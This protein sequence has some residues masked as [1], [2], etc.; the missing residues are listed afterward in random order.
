M[1]D[2]LFGKRNKRGDWSPRERIEYPPVFAWPPRP[3]AFVRFLTGLS[4]Y[5][6]PW[7]VLYALIALL[8]LRYATPSLATAQTFS[9]GW[10]GLLLARNAALVTA[11]VGLWHLVLYVLRRQ[12]TSFKFSARWP[13]TDNSAFLFKHQLADNL[14]WTYASGLP[15]WTATE[16]LMLWAMGNHYVPYVDWQTH[17]VYCFAILLAIPMFRDL[18][19]YCV[20]RLLHWPPLYRHV[21][22]LHH[23]NV[24]PIPSSGLSMH[25]VE[26]VLYY[27]S[28]LIHFVVPSNPMHLVF[29][30][31]HLSLAP[32]QGHAGFAKVMLGENTGVDTHCGSPPEN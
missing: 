32:T 28:V 22:S 13:A 10:V 12:G 24:N 8:V 27:S 2:L 11:W 6:L 26:H 18:H 9:W 16:A 29:H 14:I 31:V 30:F 4:G 15:I 5:L 7:N 21:H 25:P 17:P 3:V 20:H 19:F 1:D 23:N